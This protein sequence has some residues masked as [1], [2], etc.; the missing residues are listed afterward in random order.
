MRGRTEVKTRGIGKKRVSQLK[1]FPLQ[2]EQ[3]EEIQRLQNMIFSVGRTTYRKNMAVS[4]ALSG[5]VSTR[6]NICK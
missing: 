3:E 2:I 1:I 6:G 5:S 4:D